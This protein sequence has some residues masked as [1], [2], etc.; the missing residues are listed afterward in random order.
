[1]AVSRE[2]IQKEGAARRS[3]FV[4]AKAPTPRRI[5]RGANRDQGKVKATR[6]SP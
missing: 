6:E 4:G 2:D 5:V 1:M 3:F